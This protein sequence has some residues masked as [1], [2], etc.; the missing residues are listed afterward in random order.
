VKVFDQLLGSESYQHSKD[1]NANFTDE[2]AP[3]VQRLRQMNVHAASPPAVM[4]T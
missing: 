3:A 2:R 4:G 1:N